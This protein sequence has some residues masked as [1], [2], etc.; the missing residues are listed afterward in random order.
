MNFSCVWLDELIDT[1]MRL[2]CI[3]YEPFKVEHHVFIRNQRY[4]TVKQLLLWPAELVKAES[5][6]NK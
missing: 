6:K 3:F 2:D 1:N 5:W 4:V